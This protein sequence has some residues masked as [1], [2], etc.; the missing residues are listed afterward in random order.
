M[1][2]PGQM[3]GWKFAMW[4]WVIVLSSIVVLLIVSVTAVIIKY[5]AGVTFPNAI[6]YAIAGIVVGI[7]T[8]RKK[9]KTI[10]EGEGYV[11]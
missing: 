5:I 11:F 7:F 2:N 3:K 8:S 1:E 6:F 10:L 9:I 4:S